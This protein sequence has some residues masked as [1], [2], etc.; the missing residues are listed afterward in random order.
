MVPTAT[1]A[2][3][4]KLDRARIFFQGIQKIIQ[5]LVLGIFVDGDNAVIGTERTYPGH[6][7]GVHTR[8]LLLSKTCC[9]CSGCRHQQLVILGPLTY[10]VGESYS[11]A[12]T[13]HID[14]LHTTRD[15]TKLL[16]GVANTAACE[17]PAA[18]WI[19]RGNTV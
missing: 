17:V 1:S 6:H 7:I 4:R 11:T 13:G 19:R 8:E 5:V 9:G 12:C 3:T 15:Q 16:Q 18:A 14:G 2:A 10:G